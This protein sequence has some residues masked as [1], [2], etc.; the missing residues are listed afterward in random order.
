METIPFASNSSLTLS[1]VAVKMLKELF[2]E[3][4][5]YPIQITKAF[6]EEPTNMFM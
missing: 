4:E 1:N 3:G 6:K 2:V 5:I